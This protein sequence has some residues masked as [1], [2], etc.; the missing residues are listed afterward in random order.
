MEN[1]VDPC[2]DNSDRHYRESGVAFQDLHSREVDGRLIRERHWLMSSLCK[3]QDSL[4]SLLMDSSDIKV[5]QL[6]LPW[7][8]F[9]SDGPPSQLYVH[10]CS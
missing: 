10:E 6:A 9:A 3:F 8:I 4:V 7:F 5:L 1:I 2:L